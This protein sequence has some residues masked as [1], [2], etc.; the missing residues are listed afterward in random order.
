MRNVDLKVTIKVTEETL[1][2]DGMTLE[3]VNMLRALEGAEPLTMGQEIKHE[4]TISD[5]P[6]DVSDEEV[7]EFIETTQGLPE[8]S[9]SLA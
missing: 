3:E 4:I 6:D 1:Q 2:Y 7:V 9:V 5:V 8:G